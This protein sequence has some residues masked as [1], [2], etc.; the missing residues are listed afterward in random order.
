MKLYEL[1][2]QFTELF[3]NFEDIDNYTPGDDEE[4]PSSSTTR[5]RTSRAT[6]KV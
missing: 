5:R 6:S 3:D 1:S 4:I 2:N